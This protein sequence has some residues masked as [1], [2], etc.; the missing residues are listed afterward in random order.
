M[1]LLD[2]TNEYLQPYINLK[3]LLDTKIDQE[4]K[5]DFL[6]FVRK[7]AP[8]ASSNQ[9]LPLSGRHAD[10]LTTRGMFQQQVNETIASHLNITNA[11]EVSNECFLFNELIVF[12]LD[13]I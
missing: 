7:M 10:D 12:D 5:D 1:E 11:R 3:E 13:T 4:C 9:F 2:N 8:F 6:T